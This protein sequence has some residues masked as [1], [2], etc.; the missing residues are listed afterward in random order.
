MVTFFGTTLWTLFS[1]RTKLEGVNYYNDE[2][3]KIKDDVLTLDILMTHSL[4]YEHFKR[5]IHDK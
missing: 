1:A 4:P 3:I 2:R 5:F